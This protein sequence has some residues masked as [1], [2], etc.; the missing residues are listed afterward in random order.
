MFRHLLEKQ[1]LGQRIFE[2]N[3]AHLKAIGMVMKQG[4]II[5]ATLNAAPISTMHEQKER[6]PEMHYPK[7]GNQWFFRMQPLAGAATGLHRHG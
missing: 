6:D 7:K 2:V 4:T 1:D 3:N 5:D